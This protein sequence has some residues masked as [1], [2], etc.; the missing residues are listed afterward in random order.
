MASTSW[1]PCWSSAGRPWR[2]ASLVGPLCGRGRIATGRSG[3]VVGLA[4]MVLLLRAALAAAASAAAEDGADRA[5]ARPRSRPRSRRCGAGRCCRSCRRSRRPCVVVAL[6]AWPL[7]GTATG[8]SSA[9]TSSTT[10][11][12]TRPPRS[13]SPTASRRSRPAARGV[14]GR[15]GSRTAIRRARTSSWR[16]RSRS[17][18]RHLGRVPGRA[19][20]RPRP[21]ARSPPTGRCGA[22]GCAPA[23]RRSAGVL[24]AAGYLQYA[25][26]SEALLPQMA[27]T[28]LVFGSLG[29]GL[30]ERPGAA[31]DAVRRSGP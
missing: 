4:L 23:S 5:R 1:S 3:P 31:A 6:L 9:T 12:T 11:R 8:R 21:S 16:W 29:A 30:R 19:G 14:D 2:S 7:A 28:P 17:P 13:G 18:G 25:F 27:A 20:G 24:A 26:Y 10:R 15:P 22:P